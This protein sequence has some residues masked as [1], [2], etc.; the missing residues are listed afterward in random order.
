MNDQTTNN[1]GASESER[2]FTAAPCSA[3]EP[4]RRR[5]LDDLAN[6]GALL[7]IYDA[8][9]LLDIETVARTPPPLPNKHIYD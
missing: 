7:G 3:I 6:L 1:P 8:S 4:E 5:E 2:R 9:T